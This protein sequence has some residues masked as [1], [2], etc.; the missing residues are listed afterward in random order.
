M[1]L[2]GETQ[3]NLKIVE[4]LQDRRSLCYEDVH[5]DNKPLCI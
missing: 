1:M 4:L 2:R 5:G 3:Q